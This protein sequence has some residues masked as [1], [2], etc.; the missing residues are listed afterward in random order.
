MFDESELSDTSDDSNI[1][2]KKREDMN[3]VE[4]QV[5]QEE[6]TEIR[7]ILNS[8]IEVL[9]APTTPE[10]VSF[11]NRCLNNLI[12]TLYF[13]PINWSNIQQSH[14]TNS[15]IELIKAIKKGNY[16]YDILFQ[17][18]ANNSWWPLFPQQ[19][20]NRQSEATMIIATFIAG[21]LNYYHIK[22]VLRFQYLDA[23]FDIQLLCDILHT[24]GEGIIRTDLLTTPFINQNTN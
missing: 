7:L 24:D 3:P 2:P 8:F 1:P 20:F 6:W 5:L 15:I 21:L 18:F 14:S 16:C 23:I 17:L 4:R 13:E 10:T 12:E 22:I 19:D 9:P 11:R